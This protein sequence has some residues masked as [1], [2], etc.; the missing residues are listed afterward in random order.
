MPVSVDSYPTLDAA[1]LA[2]ES[3]CESMSWHSGNEFG[4]VLLERDGRYVYSIAQTSGLA[5]HLD[6]RASFTSEYKLV[7]LYH[8]HPQG[9]DGEVTRWFSVEDVRVATTLRVPS[10]IGI[11]YEHDV[12]KFIPGAT[13]TTLET[14]PGFPS[15]RIALGEVVK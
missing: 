10:Y 11:E 8:T 3:A 12:R 2:A 5:S 6:I 1:A 15:G 9:F 13:R 14:S 4:G 7:G